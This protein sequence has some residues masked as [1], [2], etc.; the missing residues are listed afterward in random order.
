M[1]PSPLKVYHKRLTG[2]K[3]EIVWRALECE[4]YMSIL[5]RSR[6]IFRKDIFDLPGQI[7]YKRC[8]LIANRFLLPFSHS[9]DITLI[10]HSEQLAAVPL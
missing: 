10:V 5:L 6:S 4:C 3:S 8:G 2:S 9:F 1:L 7:I